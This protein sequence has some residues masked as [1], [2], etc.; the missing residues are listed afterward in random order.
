MEDYQSYTGN[1]FGACS[2]LILISEEARFVA[3]QADL[4][5][6]FFVIRRITSADALGLSQS[7]WE[8][9][10]METQGILVRWDEHG[11]AVICAVKDLA[12]RSGV[13]II[14]L[15][16]TNG[17]EHVAALMVGADDALTYLVS[18][19]LLQAQLRAYRR[20]VTWGTPVAMPNG[21]G[22]TDDKLSRI[23]PAIPEDHEVYTVGPLMLD[24][25]ARRFFVDGYVAKLTHKEF[26][27]MTFLM[28][29][30]GIC[31]TRDEILEQVWGLNFDP[32]TSVLGT[33]IYTLRRKLAVY[34]FGD[35][36]ETVRGVGYRLV[37]EQA[38]KAD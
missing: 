17:A 19:I 12:R 3:K 27:L 9:K 6:P 31:L 8:E 7:E 38:V 5:E 16:Q 36:I 23:S 1:T 15:C 33:Q 35:L 22:M 25:T 2:L 13:P 20:L 34:G 14:A 11:P 29:R 4:L 26:D 24:C 32:G 21:D 18:P 28:Q 30:V 10:L 37:K